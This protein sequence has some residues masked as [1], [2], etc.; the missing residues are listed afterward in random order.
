[1]QLRDLPNIISVLRLLAVA[2]VMYLLLSEEYGWALVLFAAAGASDGLDGYLAKRFDWRSRLGGILD[3]LADKALLVG[4]FLILG[5]EGLVPAWLVIAV[6]LRDLVIVSGAVVYNYRVEAVEAAPLPI[7][8]L[9]TV[10]QILLVVMVIMAA[11]PFSLPGGL[12]ETM[13][14]AC[15]VTVVVSGA[16]YVWIWSRKARLRGWREH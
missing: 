13:I 4:C 12:I 16:Q 1:M 2:P 7:S 3:P 8:K 9:N 6:I 10:L 5:W 14:W 11:G 15:F